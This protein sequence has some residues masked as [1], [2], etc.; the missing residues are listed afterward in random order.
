MLEWLLI[1]DPA[2]E[3]LLASVW[4]IFRWNY[5][6][7]NNRLYFIASVRTYYRSLVGKQ[8]NGRIR[9]GGSR[10]SGLNL[11]M[12]CLLF[13]VLLHLLQSC[14]SVLCS[15]RIIEVEGFLPWGE[16]LE[17]KFSRKILRLW[18]LNVKFSGLLSMEK[19]SLLRNK[20]H[21]FSRLS[22]TL[23]LMALDMLITCHSCF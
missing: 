4:D 10:D 23:P 18:V 2:F 19:N 1:K 3:I 21:A 7:W 11:D 9:S 13:L 14:K 6:F 15:D 20:F 8:V 22:N 5:V 17:H 16:C 12:R